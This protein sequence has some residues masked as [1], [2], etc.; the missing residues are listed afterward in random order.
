M[1][2]AAYNRK[3]LTLIPCTPWQTPGE[4]AGQSDR[5]EF[6]RAETESGN[7][8]YIV[9]RTVAAD[10]TIT[11]VARDDNDEEEQHPGTNGIPEAFAND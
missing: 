9:R 2:T 11:I 3:P 7:D 4:L 8:T 1:I 6:C 5:T 10:G